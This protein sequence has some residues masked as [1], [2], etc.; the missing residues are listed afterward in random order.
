MR[1]TAQVE[2]MEE[3]SEMLNEL[4]K[5][6]PAIAAQALYEGANDVAQAILQEMG[7][8]KTAPFSYAKPGE[9]RLPSPE[10]KDVLMEAGV[11]IAKFDINGSEVNTSIGIDQSEYADVSWNHMSHTARTNSKRGS[12]NRKP[13]GAIANAINSGTSF[14]KKQPFVRK[15]ANAGTQKAVQTMKAFIE[16]ALKNITK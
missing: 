3:I 4:E 12:Q 7:K 10:E 15:G 1:Y 14:M 9:Q 6:A 16:N 8:V 11:G 5:Q 13:V 2:G